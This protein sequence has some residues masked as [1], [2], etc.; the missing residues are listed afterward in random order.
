MIKAQLEDML[1][2]AELRRAQAKRQSQLGIDP[3]DP[4]NIMSALRYQELARKAGREVTFEEAYNLANRAQTQVAGI[5]TVP[6]GKGGVRFVVDPELVSA[7][8]GGQA[9]AE[10]VGTG[11]GRAET[12][13]YEGTDASGQPSS[14]LMIDQLRRLGLPLGTTPRLLQQQPSAPSAA[15]PTPDDIRQ[16]GIDELRKLNPA[17]AM[18]E[19]SARPPLRPM[20]AS[21]PVLEGGRRAA[22]LAANRADLQVTKGEGKQRVSENLLKIQDAY[23]ELAAAGGAI[24]T[25]APPLSNII[26]RA[27]ST[28]VGQVVGQSIGTKAQEA[29]NKI[30]NLRPVLIQEIRQA[31]GM[32]ARAMDSNVELKFYLQAATDPTKDIDSNL[33]AIEYLDKTYGLGIGVKGTPEAG[34]RLSNQFSGQVAPPVNEGWSIRKK[35]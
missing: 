15:A 13:Q 6:D 12:T 19:Q 16:A 32:S 34:A 22:E 18:A 23:E 20:Q 24:K 33:A 10:A 17:A 30:N 3:K 35:P 27:M 21:G 26:N 11:I 14:V 25:G 4:A 31:T 7:L 29:R 5:A 9:R 1:A 2:Q 28:D 8:K